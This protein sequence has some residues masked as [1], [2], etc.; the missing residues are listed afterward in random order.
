MRRNE[1]RRLYTVQ[2]Q[3]NPDTGREERVLCYIGKHYTVDRRLIR[4]RRL[5]M[6]L[7]LL[8]HCA[9][10]LWAGLVPA[11]AQRCMYVLPFF[12]LCLLP[13]SYALMALYRVWRF[14]DVIDEVQRSEGLLSVRHSSA[15]LLV[16][17]IGWLMGDIVF[18]I[19][20]RQLFAIPDDLIFALCAALC[21]VCSAALWRLTR[22]LDAKETDQPPAGE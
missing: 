11:V 10:I 2:T 19:L 16:L 6:L 18:L 21:T 8:A 14:G 4:R 15:G 3:T 5:P 9:L 1:L 20:N 13:L 22:A 7:L 12:I 17:S